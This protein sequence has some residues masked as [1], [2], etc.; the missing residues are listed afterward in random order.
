MVTKRPKDDK[1][2]KASASAPQQAAS[3]RGRH[4]AHAAPSTGAPQGGSPASAQP[5]QG[6][7]IPQQ[8]VASQP[9]ARA[10]VPQQPQP[11]KQSKTVKAQASHGSRAAK[12]KDQKKRRVPLPAKIAI[13]VV[14]VAAIAGVAFLVWDYLFRYDDAA[15]FQGQWKIEGSN[16]S[17]VITEDEIRLTDSVSFTYELDTFQKTI[18]YNF[19][20]YSGEGMYVFSPERDVLTLTDVSTSPDEGDT[21]QSMSLLK[22]SNQ[23]IGEPEVANNNTAENA[24]TTGADV[25]DG[26][27]TAQQA[28]ANE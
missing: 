18:T 10:A 14:L 22:V 5:R 13:I 16:A 23:A 7:G 21:K 15:D 25:V 8:K 19:A 17:I 11:S 3:A 20:N 9:P 27:E 12:S 28:E 2:G 1:H 4:A 24:E 6:E 26:S